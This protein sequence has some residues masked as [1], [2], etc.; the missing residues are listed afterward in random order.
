MK[1]IITIDTEDGQHI[2]KWYRDALPHCAFH[3]DAPSS[4]KGSE[5]HPHGLMVAA[6]A[7]I[8]TY[9][10]PTEVH[11]LR[12]FDGQAKALPDNEWYFD[13]VGGLG[14]VMD[15]AAAGNDDSDDLDDDV[16]F[17]QRLMGYTNAI[18]SRNRA[19]KPSYFSGDGP[20]VQCT[21]MAERIWLWGKEGFQLGSGTSF[22]D[23]KA[24]G[25]CAMEFEVPVVI[26]SWGSAD[27][28]IFSHDSM[29]ARWSDWVSRYADVVGHT[30]EEDAWLE[31]VIRNGKI[32]AD[33]VRGEHHNKF[34]Y[35]D[36]EDRWNSYIQD[37]VPLNLHPPTGTTRGSRIQWLEMRE[38]K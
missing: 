4:V 16:D 1:T 7:A 14:P 27:M 26:R 30:G 29:A 20:R 32:P 6:Q 10:E 35:A 31:Y 9:P 13:Y 34:G 38:L 25:V 36:I 18:G 2:P 28:D 23:G 37:N 19:G 12:V 5:T 22:A 24:A 8:R 3:G 11:F 33:W 15:F 17:P 21:T